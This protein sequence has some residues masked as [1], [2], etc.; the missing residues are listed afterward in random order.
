MESEGNQGLPIPPYLRALV[1]RQPTHKYD[2]LT[3]ERKPYS[4]KEASKDLLRSLDRLQ[5]KAQRTL[6][7]FT[8]SYE[9]RVDPQ[10]TK[11]HGWSMVQK[12]QTP[13]T[14]FDFASDKRAPKSVVVGLLTKEGPEQE[15][16]QK[17]SQD[18]SNYFWIAPE[19]NPLT[20]TPFVYHWNP[21]EE[22]AMEISSERATPAQINGLKNMFS[23][24]KIEDEETTIDFHQF[25][26]WQEGKSHPEE[27]KSA[28]RP[29]ASFRVDPRPVAG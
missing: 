6:E 5:K 20:H 23:C 25:Q 4:L 8:G 1:L 15:G 2:D 24:R 16:G 13:G 7:S 28:A 22:R 9:R 12:Y 19:K 21:R 11:V 26:V 14:G 29:R 17:I 18:E 3:G 27:E 10:A